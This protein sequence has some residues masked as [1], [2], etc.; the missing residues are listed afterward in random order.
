M[1]REYF[2]E[3]DKEIEEKVIQGMKEHEKMAQD[4]EKETAITDQGKAGDNEVEQ[5]KITDQ[6]KTGD[7]EVEQK[8]MEDEKEEEDL[9]GIMNRSTEDIPKLR[10]LITVKLLDDNEEI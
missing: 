1:V 2:P 4:F 9:K 8:N 5:K 6:C 3:N 10:S 7:N